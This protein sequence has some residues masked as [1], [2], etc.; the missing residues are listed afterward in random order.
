MNTTI[1]MALHCCAGV[2]FHFVSFLF[3]HWMNCNAIITFQFMLV[4][5]NEL[6]FEK[7][8]MKWN[9][10]NKFM[11]IFLLYKVVLLK[12]KKSHCDTACE[13]ANKRCSKRGKCH[14]LYDATYAH[15][16]ARS[17][18]A[19]IVAKYRKFIHAR[20]QTHKWLNSFE[21]CAHLTKERKW[22]R[23]A[24]SEAVALRS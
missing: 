12:A 15:T 2:F 9:K 3:D 1:S 19:A 10:R 23:M 4:C 8:K 14:Q 21:I 20:T 11:I 22:L 13:R 17:P 7:M 5:A 6:F 16:H 18:Y 24:H